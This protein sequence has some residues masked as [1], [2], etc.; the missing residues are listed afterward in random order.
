MPLQTIVHQ[1]DLCVIGGGLAGLCAAVAAARRGVK[2][3]LMHERPVLGGNASSEIRMWVCGAHGLGNRETGLLE[4]IMMDNQYRNP[5]KNYSIWD[6]ILYEKV[7]QEENITLLLN[8]SCMDARMLDGSIASVTGW[9]MTTQRFHRVEARLFA[10]CSGDS[11]LAPLTGAPCRE[12]REARAEFHESIAPLAADSH[13]M[14]MSCLLQAEETR[15]PQPFVAPEWAEKITGDKLVHRMPDLNQITEN[16]WYL[17]LGGQRDTIGET[18]EIAAELQALAYGMWDYLKND[19]SQRGKH[20]NWRLSWVGALPGKRESRRYT[21]AFTMTENDILSGG[22]FDDEVAYGGWTMD[23]HHP[24][25]FRTAQPPNIFHPAPSPYGIPFGCLYSRAVPNLMFAGRNISVTHAAMSSTRVM[26][27]CAL[28]G[29]AI[30]TAAAVA[31]QHGCL[32]AQVAAEHIRELQQMLQD[33][34]CFL[35]HHVRPISAL[36]RNAVLEG[37]GTGLE[38]LRDGID[39]QREQDEHAWKGRVGDQITYRF[40]RPACITHIRLVMDSDLDRETLPRNERLLNR[41]L[42]HNRLLTNELSFVPPTLVKAYR[43]IAQLADGSCRVVLEVRD[44]HHR[45]RRHALDLPGCVSLTLQI[46]ETWGRE[47]VRLFAFEAD[48]HPGEESATTGG[49]IF[50]F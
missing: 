45:L 25:G 10:D 34:D 43:V 9:Q 42:F 17:E 12:G 44:N 21:G 1:T 47:Q 15:T 18:E 31:R 23:D 20:Q 41:N 3:V 22:C 27:T 28:L 16:F 13:T 29:Q 40:D 46:L 5:D 6:S 30:G 48:G 36:C 49:C 32:P 33:D 19:P 7:R 11:I 26:G 24:A 35:P 4:E 8:C 50:S 37:D 38:A 2:V 14:G 39:R